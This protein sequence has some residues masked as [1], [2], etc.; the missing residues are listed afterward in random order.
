MAK[1]KQTLATKSENDMV[2]MVAVARETLRAE[3]FK[4]VRSRKAGVIRKAKLEVAQVLTELNK[5][6]NVSAK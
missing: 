6:R 2:D 3:R 1:N 5:R 4:D